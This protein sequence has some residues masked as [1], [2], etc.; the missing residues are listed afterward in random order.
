MKGKFFNTVVLFVFIYINAIS[1]CFSQEKTILQGQVKQSDGS[2]MRHSAVMLILYN[3]SAKS[4]SVVDSSLTDENGNYKFDGSQKYFILAKPDASFANELPTYYGNTLFS[5]QATPVSMNFGDAVIADFA[6]TKKAFSNSGI[7]SIGGII[8]LGK[9]LGSTPK[10][11]VFLGDKDKNPI[12]V[13]STNVFGD[14]EFKNL[15]MSNYYVWIDFTGVDNTTA[16]VINLN[17][18]NPSKNN[19]HFQIE[20]GS[21]NWIENSYTS[22]EDALANK[23]NVYT[24]NLNSLQH[25]V[26]EK[27]LII[28]TD[29]SKKLSPK[30]EEFTNLE[31][32]SID[33]NLI[34]LL[35]AEIGKL[36]KLTTLSANLNKLSAL[37]DEME[38]LKNLKTLNLGKNDFHTFPDLIT[39][40]SSLEILNFESNPIHILPTTINALKNLHELNLAGC[41][42]LV[43]LPVEIGE[44]TNLETLDLSNCLK[45]K[46]L[47]KEFKKLTKLKILD[48]TGTKLSVKEFQKAVPGCEVRR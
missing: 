21:M 40:Y 18:L 9:T 44:L 47:P 46:S 33:I 35:P 39:K 36:S 2:P 30:I 22:I 23:K 16:D 38:N 25:D 5:Q 13:T 15:S 37:P 45:L 20:D 12:A 48:I 32:L 28:G 24:L 34:S 42:D 11:T 4:Y 43:T 3:P 29:G 14:F 17:V 26:A 41:F 1:F 6:T 27:N 7:G 10:F 19:L 31:S 8:S